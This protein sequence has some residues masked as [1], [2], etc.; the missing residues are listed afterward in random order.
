MTFSRRFHV[1][2]KRAKV[3]PDKT[4]KANDITFMY[5]TPPY[6]NAEQQHMQEISML[7]ISLLL[8]S[9]EQTNI[10]GT[11]AEF[12]TLN[13]GLPFRAGQLCG[14]PQ[15]AQVSYYYHLKGQGKSKQQRD[16]EKGAGSRRTRLVSL[17]FASY[18]TPHVVNKSS[19]QGFLHRINCGSCSA[20]G[21]GHIGDL[22][23]PPLLW[24]HTNL[25]ISAASVSNIYLKLK[26]L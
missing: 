6:L 24:H 8:R 13:C 2:L 7:V 15:W 19:L 12:L 11:I 3:S 14:V 9:L 20:P 1:S 26:L 23:S 16:A 21:G 17:S 18:F 22:Q 5:A 25:T 10:C 4:I